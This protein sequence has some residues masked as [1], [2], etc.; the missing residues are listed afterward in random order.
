MKIEQKYVIWLVLGIVAL[1]IVNR[2]RAAI[3]AEVDPAILRDVLP[4]G[5]FGTMRLQADA[6]EIYSELGLDG[7]LGFSFPW[8]NEQA[9]IK[10]LQPYQAQELEF[11]QAMYYRKFMRSLRSDLQRWL[12]VEEFNKIKY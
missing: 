2:L 8:E 7:F 10:I 6:E 1:V 4:G 3:V 9:I 12:S 11:L 5:E